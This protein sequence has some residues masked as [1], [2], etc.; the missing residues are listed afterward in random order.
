MAIIVEEETKKVSIISILA[1]VGILGII[2]AGVYYIF[3][4]QP[5]LVEYVVPPA[6][7]NINPLSQVNLK[8]DE[9]INGQGF[10]SLKPYITAPQTNNAGRPNPFLPL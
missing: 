3:F 1:W 10:Q 6:F 4:A 2:A 7:Q 8:P 5:E 9:V